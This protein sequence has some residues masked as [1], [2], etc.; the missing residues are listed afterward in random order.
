MSTIRPLAT[1]AVLAALGVFLALEINK[2]G[3]VSL[4][5]GWD[6]ESPASEASEAPAF[7]EAPPF[8]SADNGAASTEAPAFDP[9]QASVTPRTAPANFGAG[10][11]GATAPNETTPNQTTALGLPSLPQ[12]PAMPTAVM[13]SAANT[14][15]AQASLSATTTEQELQLPAMIPQAR[16]GEATNAQNQMAGQA[17][18]TIPAYAPSNSGPSISGSVPS[19]GTATGNQAGTP[20]NANASAYSTPP[21][22]ESSNYEASQTT[23]LNFGETTPI[24]PADEFTTAWVKIQEAL[25]RNELTRAH[26][27]ASQWHGAPM[28]SASQRGEVDT[29]LSELAGTVVYSLEHRL[30]PAYPVRAGETLETIAQ[31]Y[32]VPWELLAKIN[33]IATPEAVQP[34]QLLKVVRGPF[35]AEVVLSSSELVLM[36]DDR[37][38]GK[39]PVQIDGIIGSSTTWRVDQ[40]QIL[41]TG[42]TTGRMIVL[43][44][45]QGTSFALS[46]IQSP[47]QIHQGQLRVASNDASDL[48]DILS[49]GSV[50][51]IRR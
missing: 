35:D 24:A 10:S 28:L 31:Q 41:P 50:V 43:R 33:G 16:Y 45:E 29:L 1:I 39:F 48:Y 23:P 40:K 46:D 27:L 2:Q 47:A 11:L 15:P 9:S 30:E 21:T 8:N 34:G 3:P 4:D 7:G 14:A 17:S 49:V 44:N 19:L 36:L 13:P 12:L 38:A 5:S 6:S 32:Q 42:G 20:Y 51:S 26:L 37:F 25:Q 22:S 18:T